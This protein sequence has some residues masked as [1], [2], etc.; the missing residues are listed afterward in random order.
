[1]LAFALAFVTDYSSYLNAPVPKSFTQISID[2]ASGAAK[3]TA[4]RVKDFF[5]DEPEIAAVE[6]VAVVAIDWN[7]RGKGLS[8]LFAVAAILLAVIAFVR[9]ES[10]VARS[11]VDK[12]ESQV[13]RSAVDEDQ[14]VAAANK[15][16]TERAI[17]ASLALAG[18]ALAYQFVLKGLLAL[19]VG[20]IIAALLRPRKVLV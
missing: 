3:S 7:K 17:V 16:M 5:A 20:L 12:P 6:T 19:A 10:Q 1:M 2:A 15:N 9:N 11:A 14:P 18:A 13:A 8:V 4:A